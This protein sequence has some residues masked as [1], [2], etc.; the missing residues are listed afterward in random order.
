MNKND[1]Y[2]HYLWSHVALFD[3]HTARVC[4]RNDSLNQSL[5]PFITFSD[6]LNSEKWN[7]MRTDALEGKPLD[8]CW[9]CYKEDQQGLKSLRQ[10]A[11][12]HANEL[13]LLELNYLEIN[14]GNHCNLACNICCSA[15]S[16]L[17]LCKYRFIPYK[18]TR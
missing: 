13:K 14:L 12:E 2:C 17:I 15:N 8:G 11:N 18:R 9:K 10:V 6:A 3:G 7:T 4:C 16:S 5:T 1:T